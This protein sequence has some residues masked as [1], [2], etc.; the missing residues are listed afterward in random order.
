[1]L[2]QLLPWAQVP[3]FSVPPHPSETSPQLAPSDVQFAGVHWQTLLVQELPEAHI[4]Q[5][6]VSPHPS[7]TVPQF[8]P[9]D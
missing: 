9:S 3:Q 1:M 5:F 2:M 7:A 6:S 4:P 8:L